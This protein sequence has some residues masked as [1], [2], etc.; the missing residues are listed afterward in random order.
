M[1]SSRG[2]EL[3]GSGQGSV[4]SGQ[5]ATLEGYKGDGMRV[6][7]MKEL[8]WG[9]GVVHLGIIGANIPLPGRLRGAGELG[10]RSAIHKADFLCA[11]DLHRHCAG[12]VCRVVFWICSG[13]GGGERAGTVS[14]CIPGGILAAADFAAGLLLRP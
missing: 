10:G 2:G 6:V 5:W 11:L 9:A 1:L 14:E 4:V 7:G 3:E 12:A 13:T 8:I